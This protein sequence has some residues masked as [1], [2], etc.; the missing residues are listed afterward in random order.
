MSVREMVRV[1]CKDDLRAPG[2]DDVELK[3]AADSVG[4]RRARRR[5]RSAA[6]DTAQVVKEEHEHEKLVSLEASP[7]TDAEGKEQTVPPLAPIDEDDADLSQ[8][9]SSPSTAA[10]P[11]LA[12]KNGR[13]G[14]LT[15]EREASKARHAHRDEEFLGD[16]DPH[17]DWLPPNTT[18]HD[19]TPEFCL[20]LE[21]R[22]R[23]N[24]G[25]GR[26]VWYGAD[27]AGT[28]QVFLKQYRYSTDSLYLKV[29]CS[30]MKRRQG[31]LRIYLLR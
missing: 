28:C 19:Y 12:P 25:L 17:S 1:V 8:Y 10:D 31:M 11:T 13:A 2:V 23:R 21:R 6:K 27:T 5:K 29:P 15:Q 9:C 22:Y 18:S 24:C 26:P 14:Q 30:R 7:D 20:K 3:A 4:E 16:F